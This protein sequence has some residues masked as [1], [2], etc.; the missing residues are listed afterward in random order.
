MGVLGDEEELPGLPSCEVTDRLKVG[1]QVTDSA[2]VSVEHA[3]GVDSDA[4]RS[5]E[6]FCLGHRGTANLHYGQ[7]AAVCNEEPAEVG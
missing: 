1:E 6:P 5:R 2:R 4:K 3:R 7:Q